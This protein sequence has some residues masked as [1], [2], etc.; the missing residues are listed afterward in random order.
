[1][2]RELQEIGIPAFHNFE[3][4]ARAY[5]NTSMYYRFLA[6]VEDAA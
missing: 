5:R 2:R 3:R 1:M 4:A 6:S